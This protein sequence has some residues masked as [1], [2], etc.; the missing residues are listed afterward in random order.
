MVTA[1]PAIEVRAVG[2]DAFDDI[3]PLF[4]LFENPKM[5]RDDWRTM[6]FNYPWWAGRD[7]GFALY[8]EGVAVGFMGTIF[9]T[10]T[11]GGRP[12]TFC[13]TSSWIVR[14]EYRSASMLLLRPILA[15]RDCTIV[16]WTPTSR[17]YEIFAKLGFLPLESESLLLPAVAA[18]T[19]YR[20]S[21]SNDPLTL[22]PT[23]SPNTTE[24]VRELIGS[25]QH[26]RLIVLREGDATC[27]VI[28][29]PR[30][31]RGVRVADVHYIDDRPFFWHHRGLAHIAFLSTM[32]AF[33]MAIDR[34]FVEPKVPRIALRKPAKRLYR[35]AHPG[36]LPEHVDALFTEMMT[37]R[38]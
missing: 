26:L 5:H 4:E 27:S 13:N 25:R 15:M 14:D 28:A 21:F 8:A 29:S 35:P 11:I 19:S 10:R 22:D 20:G 31:V 37:L 2:I 17:S 33:G 18:P 12:E 3:A 36:I 34:R 30:N 9:S 23:F 16:N 24:D 7:R 32:G 6:L 1:P 38:V